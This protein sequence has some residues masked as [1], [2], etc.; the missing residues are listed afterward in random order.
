[1]KRR[2]LF[3]TIVALSLAAPHSVRGYGIYSHGELIDLVWDDSIRP[4][5]IQRFPGITGA[6]LTRAHSYAYGGCTIQDLGYY[7]LGP[8]FFSDLTH[9]VRSGDF[10]AALLRDASNAD[11]LAFAVGALS[12]YVGDVYGHAEAVNLSV[13]QA[14]PGLGRKYG[15]IITFEQA[16]IAHG[17][18]EMG[19]DMAQIGAHRFAPVNRSKIGFSVAQN[20]LDRAFQETYGL[21]V[22]SVTGRELRAIN[23][24][25]FSVRKLLPK[26]MQV[27]VF[28]NRERL[29]HEKDDDARREYLENIRRAR[30]TSI[31]GNEY[32]VPGVGTHALALVVRIVPKVGKLRIFRLKAPSPETSDLYFHSVNTAVRR[33]RELIGQLRQN[34]PEDLALV[35]VDLDTGTRTGPGAYRL[36]DDTYARLLNAVTTR[37]GARIPPGLRDDI[38]QFYS[39]PSAPI[40]TKNDPRAWAQVLNELRQLRLSAGP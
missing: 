25:R 6:E 23:I 1:M 4:L 12:H 37:S 35:N 38:L 13:G 33:M 5:L 29:P 18:V 36:T 11:E 2:G 32:W 17:R 8:G 40:S 34:G 21:T 27:Q 22:H 26:F 3:F 30:R 7:P 24:Y 31:S 14:F 28:I 39:D 16:E 19:F 9:Y 10:V 20:L 15:T